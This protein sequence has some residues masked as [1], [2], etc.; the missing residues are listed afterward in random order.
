MRHPK[1]H[2]TDEYEVQIDPNGRLFVRIEDLVASKGF[3]DQIERLAKLVI[4]NPPET[5][6]T[7]NC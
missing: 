4:K 1:V 6:D 5:K 2:T 7:K 3:R